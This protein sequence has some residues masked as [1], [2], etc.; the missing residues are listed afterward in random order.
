MEAMGGYRGLRY[1]AWAKSG[2]T[3]GVGARGW[4]VAPE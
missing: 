3:D 2:T 4:A 1:E